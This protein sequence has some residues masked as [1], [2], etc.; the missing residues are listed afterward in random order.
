MQC[1]LCERVSCLPP[2]YAPLCARHYL[3]AV[4]EA[5]RAAQARF[6]AHIADLLAKKKS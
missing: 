3:E 1:A 5:Q 6:Q 4:K 2:D